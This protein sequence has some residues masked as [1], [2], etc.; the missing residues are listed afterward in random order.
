MNLLRAS[1]FMEIEL[2]GMKK[3]DFIMETENSNDMWKDLHQ[4]M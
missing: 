2:E 3:F 4:H 1:K